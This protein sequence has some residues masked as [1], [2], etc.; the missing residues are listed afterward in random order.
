MIQSTGKLERKGKMTNVIANQILYPG[1][2]VRVNVGLYDQVGIV[3]EYNLWDGE[4]LVLSISCE[5][6][7]Q[8]EQKS[9]SITRGRNWTVDGYL[10]ALPAAL[11]LARA[12]HMAGRS[13]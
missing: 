3:G 6:G 7:Y 1:V 9:S 5:P 2:V 10:G 12:R 13:Y 8:F 4:P 11:V